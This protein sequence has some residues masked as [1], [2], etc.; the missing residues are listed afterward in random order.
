MTKVIGK[1]GKIHCDNAWERG[2]FEGRY[3]KVESVREEDR[4]L[5]F[6]GK[7]MLYGSEWDVEFP[8]DQVVKTSQNEQA[9]VE[10]INQHL[11]ESSMLYKLGEKLQKSLFELDTEVKG[12]DHSMRIQDFRTA[13]HL[14]S[15]LDIVIANEADFEEYAE[16]TQK[17][18]HLWEK[19]EDLLGKIREREVVF[20]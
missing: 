7:V 18:H 1:I 13:K 6:I 5:M 11:S 15:E 17:I 3:M 8:A 4:G 9:Q 2:L 16:I 14:I 20:L 19:A 10:A 12:C